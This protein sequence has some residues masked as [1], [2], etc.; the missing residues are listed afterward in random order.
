MGPGT[1]LRFPKRRHARA[2]VK[3]PGPIEE[4]A[5]SLVS[6]SAVKPAL[7]A[8]GDSSIAF[9][10]SDGMLLRNRHL[11]ATST[12]APISDAMASG[13][14]QSLITSRNEVGSLMPSL[15]GQSV[16]N[17]KDDVSSDV[18]GHFVLQSGMGKTQPSTAFKRAFTAQIKAA[19]EAKGLK[20]DQMGRLIGLSQGSY[21]QYEG[22]TLMPHELLPKFCHEAGIDIAQLFKQAHAAAQAARR[23]TA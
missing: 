15:L 20:Q 19:R 14:G 16:L 9:H 7:A 1:V 17:V 10:Q 22:R 6:I 3:T 2:S 4:R 21:K 18:A 23:K 12:L 13:E 11:R 8:V 5:A